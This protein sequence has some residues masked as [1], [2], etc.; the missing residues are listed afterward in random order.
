MEQAMRGKRDR[1]LVRINGNVLSANAPFPATGH[2]NVFLLSLMDH[3]KM[4]ADPD[5]RAAYESD[6]TTFN[7]LLDLGNPGLRSHRPGSVVTITFE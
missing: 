5:A 6:S 7:E 2:P 4:M 1:I 3:D